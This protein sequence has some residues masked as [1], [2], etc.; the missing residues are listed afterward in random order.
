[1][2]L[3]NLFVQKVRTLLKSS[4]WEF[5]VADNHVK[6]PKFQG[7]DTDNILENLELLLVYRPK[8]TEEDRAAKQK[9]V[10]LTKEIFWEGFRHQHEFSQDQLIVFNKKI[11]DWGQAWIRRFPDSFTNSC[12]IVYRHIPDYLRRYQNLY[13]FCQQGVEGTVKLMKR[14]FN[15]TMST[16]AQVTV[17]LMKKDNRRSLRVPEKSEKLGGIICFYCGGKGHVRRSS[18][19]CLKQTKPIKRK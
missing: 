10:S 13:V 1:M 8:E 4:T 3:Q 6:K 14:T 15:N 7:P 16:S 9:V 17:E 12:H 11:T 19:Q 2:N 5:K 18:K